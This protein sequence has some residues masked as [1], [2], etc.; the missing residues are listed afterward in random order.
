MSTTRFSPTYGGV[1]VPQDSQLSADEQM[2]VQVISETGPILSTPDGFNSFVTYGLKNIMA[3]LRVPVK[4]STN[5]SIPSGILMYI[6]VVGS[7]YGKISSPYEAIQLHETYKGELFGQLVMLVPGKN[8]VEEHRSDPKLLMEIPAMTGSIVDPYANKQDMMFDSG[9]CPYFPPGYV[10][11]GGAIIHVIMQSKLRNNLILVYNDKKEKQVICSTTCTNHQGITT[12]V[13]M[14]I[15]EDTNKLSVHIP[16]FGEDGTKKNKYPLFPLFSVLGIENIDDVMNMIVKY[17]PYIHEETIIAMLGQNETDGDEK[18]VLADIKSRFKINTKINLKESI[19]DQLFPSIDDVVGSK[20]ET[21]AYMAAKYLKWKA[22]ITVEDD[23]NSIGYTRLETPEILMMKFCAKKLEAVWATT[24][25]NPPT[26]INYKDYLNVTANML[27]VKIGKIGEKMISAYKKGKWSVKS[28]AGTAAKGLSEVIQPESLIK[29]YALLTK[30][31]SANNTKDKQVHSRVYHSSQSKY[32]DAKDAHEGEAIGLKRQLSLTE[33]TSTTKNPDAI[34]NVFYYDADGNDIYIVSDDKDYEHQHVLLLNGIIRGWC[35][36]AEM[37]KYLHEERKSGGRLR[38]YFDMMVCYDEAEDEVLVY[39]D[40]GRMT[41]PLLVANEDGSGTL[42]GDRTGLTLQEMLDEG[43]VEFVDSYTADKSVLIAM[44]RKYQ[45]RRW[46]EIEELETSGK[47][48]QGIAKRLGMKMFT[49]YDDKEE[50]PMKGDA[51]KNIIS[52]RRRIAAYTHVEIAPS[53]GDGAA[54]SLIPGIQHNLGSKN[55]YACNIVK[56]TISAH[57]T[58]FRTTTA[59]IMKYSANRSRP[60]V[61]TCTATTLGISLLPTGQTINLWIMP[62]TGNSIY[63]GDNQEDAVQVN[64]ASIDRGLFAYFVVHQIKYDYNDGNKGIAG[65]VKIGL[66]AHRTQE[67]EALDD[68]GIIKTNTKIKQ[69]D[70]LISRQ[71]RQEDGAY[72]QEDI[73]VKD[74]ET[75]VIDDVIVIMSGDI[76]QRITIKLREYR[77]PI[78]GSKFSTRYGNKG[79]VGSITAARNMP[80]DDNGI[81]PDMVINPLGYISRQTWALL[82]EMLMGSG[83]AVIGMTQN[84][85]SFSEDFDIDNFIELMRLT[86]NGH[87]FHTVQA[88]DG[89]TGEPYPKLVYTGQVYM[90]LLAHTPEDKANFRGRADV[91]IL[92]NQSKKGK[93]KGGNIRFGELE[94]NTEV[95]TGAAAVLHDIFAYDNL[96][97]AMGSNCGLI[98]SPGIDGEYRCTFCESKGEQCT[99][100]R[101]PFAGPQRYF[102]QQVSIQNIRLSHYPVAKKTH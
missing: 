70:V 71:V 32:N 73:K 74:I 46:E 51:L 97:L 75:G 45:E 92:T 67:H 58:N 21:L 26:S 6:D 50:E 91:E 95:A 79:V 9:N 52:K 72:L 31:N 43:Y 48:A 14:Y 20:A 37:V 38:A 18:S 5:S 85:T 55:S 13:T 82:K 10:I 86:G 23:R 8:G 87:R 36:G 49:R 101:V 76:Y 96:P 27:F 42:I 93:K 4:E 44:S 90:Q 81:S 62:S 19:L 34:L 57:Q 16:I 59:T 47:F 99:V 24:D 80:R 35:N 77:K 84:G 15:D 11:I 39:C 17:I 25:I 7:G 12:K 3:S 89:R 56:Q 28:A 1:V 98:I 40:A 66:P 22:G 41:R 69:G 78:K 54:G 60:L 83:A 100:Y 68:R 2:L 88:Y 94:K 102:T 53:A 33:Y 29:T 64:E 65:S 61:D 63:G 30:N